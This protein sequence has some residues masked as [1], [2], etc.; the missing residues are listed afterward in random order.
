MFRRH[1]GL[2]AAAIALAGT[3]LLAQS[4]DRDRAE[5]LSQRAAD[6]LQALHAEADRLAA[7]ER[8]LLGD[9]R[10]LEIE[11]DIKATELTNARA[12]VIAA[13]SELTAL[14][15]QVSTL[16]EQSAAA[17]PDL[18]ARLVT[19]YK[20]GRGRY[21]RLLLSAS[22][23]RQLGQAVRLVSALAEQDRQRMFQHQ[24]RLDALR[25]ARDTAAERQ[26]E[27]Q[28]LQAVAEKATISSERALQAHSALIRD[29]DSQRDLNARYSG[30]LQSAQQRLQ[31]SLSGMASAPSALPIAPFRG[32]LP[33]PAPGSVRQGFGASVAGR[34]PLRGIEIEPGAPTMVHAVHDGMVAYA[35]AFTGYGRLVILD[36]GN[37]TFTLY[38]NLADISVE[39]GAQVQRGA[40]LGTVGVSGTAE[41]V[42]YFELRV[43][44]RAVDP[45]Q[46]LGKR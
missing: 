37:Q 4:A 40:A 27:L 30:E 34:P 33:W 1:L 45:L 17:L 24:R 16:S 36:H 19:L 32:D 5:T 22:D 20:L 41:P 7:E 13:A 26:R 12:D 43:D 21:A 10:R 35:D 18:R 23:L 28:Q 29:I 25:A 31:A 2:L 46:W 9:L 14:D 8:T 42:L 44:G 3:V 38:G 6:R 39:K 11:R 15:Q